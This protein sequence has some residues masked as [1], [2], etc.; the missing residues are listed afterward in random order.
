MSDSEPDYGQLLQTYLTKLQ[1]STEPIRDWKLLQHGFSGAAVFWM[2]FSSSGDAFLK[3]TPFIYNPVV[4][5]RGYRELVFYRD[6]ATTIPLRV[7]RMLAHHFDGEGSALLLEAYQPSPV[8]AQWQAADFL[9]VAGQL[10]AFHATYWD[11]A[12]TLA[13]HHELHHLEPV[14]LHKDI[15][16]ALRNWEVLLKQARLATVFSNLRQAPET[17][18]QRIVQRIHLLTERLQWLG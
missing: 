6:L 10:G 12:E 3:V 5:Q 11:R 18:I 15:Q 17:D 4:A 7:A 8:P 13:G 16:N 9:E 2:H 1:L 14:R